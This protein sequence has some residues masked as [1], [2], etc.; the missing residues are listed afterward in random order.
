[1]S[2]PLEQSIFKTLSYFDLADYPLTKEELFAYLWQPPAMGYTEFLN[3]LGNIGGFESEGG[4]Y[5]LPNRKNIIAERQCR[6]L[7]SEEKLRIARKA[8]KKIRSVPFLRAI[9]V[10]NSVGEEQALKDSDIDFFIVTEK[11]RIWIVRL[12]VTFILTIFGLR[13]ARSRIKNKICLSFYVTEENLDL[14]P[15][16]VAEDDIH[17]AYWLNQ[18]VPIYDKNDNYKKFLEANKWTKKYLPNINPS[19]SYN[20]I[21]KIQD[22]FFGKIWKLVWEKM[23]QGAYGNLINDQAKKIQMTKMKFS[24]KEIDRKGDK[25]VVINDGVLKFHE[26]DTR[27]EYR[28]KW[29]ERINNYSKV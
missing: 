4:Y 12:F 23:W 7:N 2:S 14:S 25:G 20:Y 26:K 28:E 13:R 29:R 8:A 19:K 3:H 21:L 15:W 10:C 1:M 16:R 11:K 27:M 18:M 6:L 24:G 22:S 17:F 5:F 9:F